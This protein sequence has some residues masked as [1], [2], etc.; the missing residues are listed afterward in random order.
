MRVATRK[1]AKASEIYS[2]N[3]ALRA[4]VNL[5]PYVGGSLDILISSRGQSI[6]QKRMLKF[7]DELK[8]EMSRLD[9]QAVNK[10]YLE[11]EEWFDIVMRTLEAV[12]KTRNGEKVR[13]YAKMLSS[14]VS[15]PAD[16]H[17]SSEDYLT[18]ISELTPRE[19]RVARV[20]FNQQHDRPQE[21][22]T[23]LQWA[24]GKGWNDMSEQSQVPKEELQFAL[25][26]LQRA[27]LA[28]EITGTLL[29]YTGGV[30]VITDAFRR[31]M[32]FLR[33]RPDAD[34]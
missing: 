6:I 31:L 4:A 30:Y 7:L 26:R 13:L 14:S 5:V 23:E 28:K 34:V 12:A 1:L 11:S 20:L 21:T 33:E 25:L 19:I 24:L 9:E 27:G 22:E 32:D 3:A 18:I 16:L 8:V 10:A 15:T 2:E 29:D 17:Y